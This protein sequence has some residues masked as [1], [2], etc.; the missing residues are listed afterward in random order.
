MQLLAELGLP[1][2]LLWIAFV[3]ATVAWAALVRFRV[4]DRALQAIM[5]ALMTAAISWFIHSSADWLW[6]LAAVSLP[7]L[8][9][10]GG[11]AGAGAGRSG[12]G[13]EEGRRWPWRYARPVLVV[14]ILAVLASAALP[15]L[16]LRYA[17]AA[18]G[19]ATRDL[20]SA[21]A[22]AE[23]AAALDPLPPSHCRLLQASTRP[24]PR[25]PSGSATQIA[26]LRLAAE[27]FARAAEIEPAG[28]V[29][30]YQAAEA[31]L[32]ARDA[33]LD[34][35]DASSAALFSASAQRYLDEAYRLNPLSPRVDEL[36]QKLW[37][38]E[39]RT[40]TLLDKERKYG[41]LLR[42]CAITSRSGI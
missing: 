42:M 2:L 17:V 1:G 13:M 5:A 10:S 8:M 6:Q 20:E 4:R 18:A 19:A 11:L 15:Y 12:P 3:V 22:A 33:A 31:Y 41:Y 27:A 34:G 24:R 16:S 25:R 40:N 26:Y 39:D 30:H 7:A 35:G 29:V 37:D 14:L 38:W 36:Q 21:L 9:L 23:T 32:A 28:W